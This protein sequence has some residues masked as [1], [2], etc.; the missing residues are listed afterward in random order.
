MTAL[1]QLLYRR[2]Q[3][4]HRQA[5]MVLLA[6]AAVLMLTPSF[7]YA[8]NTVCSSQMLSDPGGWGNVEQTACITPG[9]GGYVETD[10]DSYDGNINDLTMYGVAAEGVVFDYFGNQQ[11]D[12]G[13]Q[14]GDTSA[15]GGSSEIVYVP[16]QGEDYTLTGYASDC[17]W[18]ANSYS[19]D[20][21]FQDLCWN[22][23]FPGV[24]V[25]MQQVPTQP[26]TLNLTASTLTST[27]GQP[28][29][30]TATLNTSDAIGEYMLFTDVYVNPDGYCCSYGGGYATLSGGAPGTSVATYTINMPVTFEGDPV[31]IYA[32]Y[33]GD[34]IYS[35]ASSNG[36]TVTDNLPTPTLSVTTSGTPSM[37]G[38]PVTFTATINPSGLDGEYVTF[39]DKVGSGGGSGIISGNTATYTTSTL[40]LGT[41]SIYTY[42]WGYYGGDENYNPAASNTITQVVVNTPGPIT[43][44]PPPPGTTD[45][46]YT[47][48]PPGGASGYAA[49]GNLLSYTDWV[50]GTWS[51]IGYDGLNRLSAATQVS[52][53][54]AT[55]SY[56]WTYDSFGNRTAQ[57]TSNQPFA[58]APGAATCQVASG[59]TMTGNAWTSYTVNG[60]DPGNNRI[61]ATAAGSYQPDAA[62]NILSDGTNGYTYDGEGR[63]CAVA[64]PQYTG[65]VI[66]TQY[67]YDAE[68]TRVAKGGNTNLNAGCDTS[69]PTFTLTN[70]YI[71]GPSGEQ[72]TETDGQGNWVHTNVYAAGQLLATYSYTDNSHAA[73]D[74]YFALSD[75][76][77]TKRAVVSAGGCGTGY[78]G[79]PYGDSLTATSLP[80]FTQCPDATEHHFT[81]KERDAESGNDYFGAR[82]YGSSMGRFMSPDWS[83]KAE[84][85]PYAKLDD[86]QTLNL[87]SYVGNNP[88]SKADADGHCYSLGTCWQAFKDAF[89]FKVA[90]GSGFGAHVGGTNDRV[91]VE[92][93]SVRES[94]IR[95]D[96]KGTRKNIDSASIGVK[97]G[98]L[99][100]GPSISQEQT[101]QT[102]NGETNYDAPKDPVQGNWLYEIGK[103]GKG[104]SDLNIGYGAGGYA[105]FGGEFEIGLKGD[106]VMRELKNMFVDPA[107]PPPP[108]AP[109]PPSQTS[110]NYAHS[111]KNKYND[112]GAT[113]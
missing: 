85:V 78:V 108:A 17:T 6:I 71:I 61:V 40:S 67:I 10:N 111:D 13:M 104:D 20:Y 44:A 11:Y 74:T 54:G 24:S 30:I 84:P 50:N 35:L 93:K 49:N 52:V 19:D 5:W 14:Y 86:P 109:P 23:P 51:N 105:G 29:T 90:F 68:G 8:Q 53:G 18:S 4:L 59:A 60:V 38:Q 77:G 100:L 70:T 7:A 101:I 33:P 83:A 97:L 31:G 96:N 16:F 75:W 76:L 39:M 87:Y 102:G 42:Y 89:Y 15:T 106:V 88:L 64:V 3:F 62:G 37:L 80:G 95:F 107:P 99:K 91:T 92:A 63:L 55:Q 94:A 45:Y 98:P 22:N 72:L 113:Q 73:T 36:L 47:I 112:L 46:S 69:G 12:S 41:H 9:G 48:T 66:L 43:Y 32:T 27:A 65:G 21:D 28:V 34:Q 81:G 58:N 1:Q 25:S 103:N 110:N 2:T 79:L 56:C 26:T 82:Y 57:A